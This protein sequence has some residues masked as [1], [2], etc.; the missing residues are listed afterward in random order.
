MQ[1]FNLK[2]K[3]LLLLLSLLFVVLDTNAQSVDERIAAHRIWMSRN[4]PK[5]S[6]LSDEKLLIAAIDATMSDCSEP[7]AIALI[8]AVAQWD[9]SLKSYVRLRL[10]NRLDTA[11]RHRNEA[12]SILHRIAV[13]RLGRQSVAAAWCNAQHAGSLSG[14]NDDEAIRLSADAASTLSD[15]LKREP[16]NDD[17]RQRWFLTRLLNIY[18]RQ[19]NDGDNPLLFPRLAS[20]ER[21]INAF[22]DKN[23][24]TENILQADI[25]LFLGILKGTVTTYPDAWRD[26]FLDDF[27]NKRFPYIHYYNDETDTN[28][29]AYFNTAIDIK[30]R[31]LSENHPE[32]LSTYCSREYFRISKHIVDNYEQVHRMFR[33]NID[34]AE[35]YLPN[36]SLVTALTKLLLWDLDVMAQQNTSETMFYKSVLRDISDFYGAESEEM[37]NALARVITQQQQSLVN[38]APILAKQYVELIDKVFA[39]RPIEKVS[40]MLQ[41][42]ALAISSTDT[43]IFKGYVEKICDLYRKFH[44]PT[45]P[46]VSTGKYLANLMCNTAGNYELGNEIFDLTLDDLASL[47]G[48]NSPIFTYEFVQKGF[49]AQTFPH[50]QTEQLYRDI[51]SNAQLTGRYQEQALEHLTTNLSRPGKQQEAFSLL[52][53]AIKKSSD[54]F[55]RALLQLNLGNLLMSNGEPADKR[56]Y[57]KLF[58]DAIPVFLDNDNGLVTSLYQNYIYIS[59]FYIGQRRYDDAEKILRRGIENYDNSYGVYDQNYINLLSA[60][61]SLYADTLN[62]FDKAEQVVE[63]P[64]ADLKASPLNTDL[65]KY[66]QLLWN[67]YY[68]IKRRS[69]DD[70]IKLQSQLNEIMSTS[71][72]MAAQAGGNVDAAINYGMPMIVEMYNIFE[73]CFLNASTLGNMAMT[74]DERSKYNYMMDYYKNSIRSQGLTVLQYAM[75]TIKSRDKNYK[76]LMLYQNL[77][78][79]MAIHYEYIDTDLTKAEEYY[80]QTVAGDNEYALWSLHSTLAQFYLR[81]NMQQKA[82]QEMESLTQYPNAAEFYLSSPESKIAHNSRLFGCYMALRQWDNPRLLQSAQN[83]FTQSKQLILQNFDF[84]TESE[85]ENYLQNNGDGTAPLQLLLPHLGNQ[86]S[87]KVYDTALWQKGLQLRSTERIRRSILKSG[88]KTMLAQLDT[89]ASLNARLKTLSTVDISQMSKEEMVQNGNQASQANN[90]IWQVRK[91][92]ERLERSVARASA[93]YRKDSPE[94]PTWQ[95]VRKQLRRDEAAIEFV[96][97]DSAVTALI[98]RPEYDR[99]QYVMLSPNIE[100]IMEL[101][102]YASRSA[103]RRADALYMRDEL[104]LYDRLWRPMEKYLSG[105]KH[106]YYSPTGILNVLA[107]P[108]LKV[109]DNEWLCDKYDLHMMTSTAELVTGMHNHSATPSSAALLGGIYYSRDQATP[110]PDGTRGAVTGKREAFPFLYNTDLE[111]DDIKGIMSQ[112]GIKATEIK[113]LDATQAKLSL[114]DNNSPDIIHLSTHGFFINNPEDMR[115]NK[116]LARFPLANQIAMQRTGLALSEANKAWEGAPLPEEN[117]GIITANEVAAMNLDKTRL[118]VLSACETGLGSYSA[119]GVWGLP[120]GFKQAGVK[121]LMASLWEV[122]DRS[123]ARFMEDFYRSWLDGNSMQQAWRDAMTSIRSAHPSPYYWAPFILMDSPR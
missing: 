105:V 19:S 103:R 90:R 109:A 52:R 104:H 92:I 14:N 98:L 62:N 10:E 86:I 101:N 113:G 99:P 56:E 73:Y 49:Y 102:K 70:F 118:V 51:Y 46:S 20:L 123:T 119:E 21:E 40:F 120:R 38:D 23:H 96:F 9:T 84:M 45:W 4:T 17:T 58:E 64:L 100:W 6:S 35:A 88:D 26:A 94:P 29:E 68:V 74:D 32:L 107:I 54:K 11:Y 114:Y 110:N 115:N 44:A 55:G 76:Y 1:K 80:R 67:R 28:A 108:A 116:F 2:A 5:P 75:E 27:D 18:S 15:I 31:L 43:D 34:F 33:E 50:E 42:Y 24:V 81:H 60:L 59:S 25:Y 22:Y 13:D 97:C 87:D 121:S 30:K 83:I 71:T 106:I 12:L 112:C 89:I 66:L 72:R 122:D 36:G 63:K 65:G 69:P 111:V 85:R 53:T 79:C 57:V 77:A 91:E 93:A 47:T 39:D 37:A 8:D 95:Q 3:A 48:K 16:D 7:E 78:R 41:L 82:A 117:D 61:Y